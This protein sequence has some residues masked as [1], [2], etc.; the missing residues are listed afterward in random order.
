MKIIKV[1]K[2]EYWFDSITAYQV[3]KEVL[4]FEDGSIKY[5]Y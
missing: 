1:I 5:I 2:V 3:T 4:F